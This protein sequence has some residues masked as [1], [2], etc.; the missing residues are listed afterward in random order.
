V[1]YFRTTN[2]NFVVTDNRAITPADFDPYCVDAPVDERLGSVSGSRLCDLYDQTRIVG[3][4]NFVTLADTLGVEPKNTYNGV[5]VSVN[6]RFGNGGTVSGGVG[7]GQTVTDNCYTIDRPFRP[8]YCRDENPWAAGT[9]V[10][11]LGAYPLP[12]WDLQLSATFQNRPGPGIGATRTY[13]NAEIRPSLGHN[14][15]TGQTA[16]I[17]LLPP[18]AQFESR[19]SQ[20]DFRLTKSIRIQGLRAQAQFDVYNLFNSNAVLGSSSSYTTAAAVWPRVSSVLAARLFKF[21][22]QLDWQ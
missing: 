3:A 6:A 18:N 7:I 10:K 15:T 22:V 20:T 5:D 17:T 2:G 19:F 14:V 4:N 13:G 21:G 9:E 11:L 16:S 12:W 8:G 1:G